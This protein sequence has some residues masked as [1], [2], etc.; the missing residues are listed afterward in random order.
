MRVLTIPSFTI[1]SSFSEMT[2]SSASQAG[3]LLSLSV[4]LLGLDAVVNSVSEAEE[5]RSPDEAVAACVLK[6][7][8]LY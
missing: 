3:W 6:S 4:P 2:I 7:V 8:E 1:A 5:G